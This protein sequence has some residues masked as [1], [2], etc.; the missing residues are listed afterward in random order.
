MLDLRAYFLGLAVIVALALVTWVVSI[1]KRDVS[2]V[3]SLW[4][5]LFVAATIVYVSQSEMPSLRAQLLLLLVAAWAFR[6]AIYLAARNWGEPE[7]RR[8]QKIR[9]RNQPNFAFKSLYIV[10]LLQGLLAWVISLPLLA[11]STSRA[12]LTWIDCVGAI[13]VTAGLLLESISDWQLSRFKSDP[14]NIDKVMNQG[15]WRYTR[16]PNYFGDCCVWWGFYL[17]A[18]SAGGWWSAVGPLLMTI[19]LLR[20]SGVS[21]LERD[22]AKR[23]PEYRR[24]METTNAFI[25]GPQRTH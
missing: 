4:S 15:L 1:F 6:L 9:A 3:D 22:I 17:L 2:I 19:L 16:H 12:E 10:F 13:A 24:Y 18:L 21:L 8:Y 5:I 23:R 7:D 14:N 11:A 25:P 20:V